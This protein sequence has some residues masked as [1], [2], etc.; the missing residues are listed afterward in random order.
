MFA[1]LPKTIEQVSNKQLKDRMIVKAGEDYVANMLTIYDYYSSG[2]I[3]ALYKEQIEEA[4]GE[5]SKGFAAPSRNRFATDVERWQLR[6]DL[7]EIQC[8]RH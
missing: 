4:F 6:C 3:A 2:Y 7:L 1:R 8:A 5:A